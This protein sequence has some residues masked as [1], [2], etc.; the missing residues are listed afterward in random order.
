M[1]TVFTICERIFVPG[2]SLVPCARQARRMNKN[3]EFSRCQLAQ[4][5]DWLWCLHRSIEKFVGV[6]LAEGGK[7]GGGRFSRRCYFTKGADEEIK[8]FGGIVSSAFQT[9]YRLIGK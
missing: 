7:R 5:A 2:P 4:E 9:P 3:N 6:L 8:R 1:C